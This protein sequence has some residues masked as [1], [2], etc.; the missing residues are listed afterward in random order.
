MAIGKRL[1]DTE[2]QPA[3]N[4][5]TTGFVRSSSTMA[6]KDHQVSIL[7]PLLIKYSTPLIPCRCNRYLVGHTFLFSAR[8]SNTYTGCSIKTSSSSDGDDDGDDGNYLDDDVDED[9]DKHLGAGV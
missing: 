7:L 4:K 1:A 5:A 6:V 2:Y 8:T 9:D 3:T